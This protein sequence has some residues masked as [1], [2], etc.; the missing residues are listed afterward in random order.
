VIPGRASRPAGGV[1]AIAV[2][3]AVLSYPLAG[4]RW[5]PPSAPDT[6]SDSGSA[7]P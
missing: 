4:A 3:S 6:G 7:R 1:L 2:I 5:P